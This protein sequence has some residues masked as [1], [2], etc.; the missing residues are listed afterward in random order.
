[1]ETTKTTAHFINYLSQLCDYTEEVANYERCNKLKK[2]DNL[3]GIVHDILMCMRHKTSLIS[4]FY[5]PIS[6]TNLNEQEFLFRGLLESLRKDMFFYNDPVRYQ[7]G[8]NVCIHML[9]PKIRAWIDD[10]N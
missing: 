6:K 1:M 4:Y 7:H 5:M 9:F 10:N 8:Y 3:L 2:K